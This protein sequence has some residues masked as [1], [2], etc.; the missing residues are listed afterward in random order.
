MALVILEKQSVDCAV[1]TIPT[2]H[3]W[4]RI[5]PRV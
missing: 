4:P 3:G 1:R 2:I 5:A